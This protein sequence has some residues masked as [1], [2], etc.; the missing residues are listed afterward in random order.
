M[1]HKQ[2]E[3]WIARQ[4]AF[5][6]SVLVILVTVFTFVAAADDC[7]KNP[8]LWFPNPG[9]ILTDGTVAVQ[10]ATVS[11]WQEENLTV[12][13]GETIEITVTV[14]NLTCGDAGPFDVSIYYD[15]VN[16]TNLIGME[17][18]TVGLEAC[19]YTVLSF[20]W[21]TTDVAPGQHSIIGLV[22]VQNEVDEVTET[23]NEYTLSGTVTVRPFAPSIEA[24][25]TYLD[26]NSGSPMPGDTITYEI[27]ITNDGCQ[28]QEDNSG[29]E[30]TDT[31]PQFMAYVSGSVNAT[32][33]TA[34][35]EQDRIVWDGDIPVG[36]IITII[37]QTVI[38]DNTPNQTTICNQGHVNWDS[39]TD[40]TNDADEPTDDPGTAIDDDPTCLVVVRPLPLITAEKTYVYANGGA[41]TPG[42]TLTYSIVI[43][44]DGEADQGNNPGHEFTD[45]LPQFMTYVSGSATATSGTAT[46]EEAQVIWDGSI[47]AGKAVTITFQVV[48]DG[49][50]PIQTTICNQGIVHW[51]STGDA[52]NDVDTPTDDPNTQID[53]DPTCVTVIKPPAAI[54]VTKKVIYENGSSLSPNDT[55]T[56]EIEIY[57][58]GSGI[59]GD[60]P[61]H[62]FVDPLPGFISY[63]SGSLSASSGVAS[64]DRAQVIWDGEIPAHGV[65]TIRFRGKVDSDVED[66]QEIC[67]QG[68]VHWDSDADGTNDADEPTDD[69]STPVDDDPTCLTVTISDEPAM[70]GTI[71]APTLSEWAQITI[72][73]LLSIA[74]I[75][76]P[77]TAKE[78]VV[79]GRST[80]RSTLPL[81]ST[82]SR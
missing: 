26:E 21:N 68:H 3:K 45:A 5:G 34:N 38:Y 60:N 28:A 61:G 67:N 52:V 2:E 6:A 10:I 49:S 78:S 18:I 30:F 4:L 19:Q 33:G 32:G 64:I 76:S 17:R 11:G 47:A 72:S 44:N 1:L 56:Y 36:G 7:Q 74:S 27:T 14:D 37:F 62:E 29:H 12:C 48:I 39:D 80:T 69:P 71:D 8:D 58:H 82:T 42:D 50:T 66:G 54:D 35:I 70:V 23:N 22:D 40:G 53:D 55:V 79:P 25:K 63:V 24:E 16:E 43:R 73:V 15:Q 9:T 75:V 59:Q 20:N 51:D 57:N 81:G 41:P 13:Q 65:I 46:I 77:C 31:I